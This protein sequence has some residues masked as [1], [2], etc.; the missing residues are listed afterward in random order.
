MGDDRNEQK[1]KQ[2]AAQQHN[3][4]KI[5]CTYSTYS[6]YTPRIASHALAK[7]AKIDD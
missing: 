2:T 4:Q 6:T 1:M 5:R 7:M 3:K